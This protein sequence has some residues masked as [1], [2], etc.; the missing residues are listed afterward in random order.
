MLAAP[1]DIA[2]STCQ[3]W[4]TQFALHLILSRWHRRHHQIINKILPGFCPHLIVIR[5]QV[6]SATLDFNFWEGHTDTDINMLD[7]LIQLPIWQVVKHWGKSGAE[8][9]VGVLGIYR[10]L[11]NPYNLP[12]Q[13][14][15]LSAE[16]TYTPERIEGWE[17]ISVNNSTETNANAMPQNVQNLRAGY[18]NF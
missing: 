1:N 6:Y 4:T 7:S 13:V 17:S 8:N 5:C 10:M 2:G 16:E 15:S 3:C 9:E 14:P 18:L 11:D 12:C